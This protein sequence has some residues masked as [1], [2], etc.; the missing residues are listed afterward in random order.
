MTW[1]AYSQGMRQRLGIASCLVRR[2]RL[3]LLN[4]PAN[5]VDPAGLRFLRD[6]LRR[7]FEEGI[8]IL[9]SSHLLSEVQE[10]C[11]RVAVINAGRIAYEGSLG[12]LR[13]SVLPR[14]RLRST[15]LE[16][17]RAVCERLDAVRELPVGDGELSFST[18]GL[19]THRAT[20]RGCYISSMKA[21]GSEPPPPPHRS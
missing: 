12:E 19:A 8:T 17:A 15:D 13:T 5:G 4:E 3:L 2:P 6:L 21:A 9:L 1:S 14:Y 20:S 10:V 18:S 11:T 7:L 16:R